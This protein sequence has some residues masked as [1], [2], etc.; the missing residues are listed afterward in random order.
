M[1]RLETARPSQYRES[2][3]FQQLR[4]E[5]TSAANLQNPNRR[6]IFYIKTFER[7]GDILL[8]QKLE[9]ISRE[10]GF[11]V[12]GSCAGSDRIEGWFA[13]ATSLLAPD[14]CPRF[15]RAPVITDGF[16]YYFFSGGVWLRLRAEFICTGGREDFVRLSACFFP[17]FSGSLRSQLK[18]GV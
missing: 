17:R 7:K 4:L 11:A 2:R 12:S 3:R 6:G 9:R 13:P 10:P 5:E 1:F 18:R 15:G 8:S 16:S 14:V